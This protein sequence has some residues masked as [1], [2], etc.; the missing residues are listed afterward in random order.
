MVLMTNKLNF[1]DRL[2]ITATFLQPK[3]CKKGKHD[4]A[5]ELLG[6]ITTDHQFAEFLTLPGYERLD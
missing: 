4:E 3:S 5:A 2:T 1:P 6:R